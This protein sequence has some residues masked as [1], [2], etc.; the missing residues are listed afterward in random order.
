M[1][2]RRLVLASS[3]AGKAREFAALMAGSGWT[4]VLPRDAGLGRMEVPE[5]ARSYLENATL[6]AVAYA[7]ASGL[8]ALADDSGL[9]VDAL[10]GRP[11]VLSARFGGRRARTDRE[12]YE[13]L[14]RLLEGVP[15]ARRGARFRAVLV[16]ADPNGLN[17]AREGTVE[18]RIAAAPRG[19][20]GFGY[21]PVFELPDGRTMAELG[22][23]KQHLSHRARAMREM[24]AVL[25]DLAAGRPA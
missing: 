3:N 24:M 10:E 20:N 23:E 8:P 21:D 14:L 22:D 17:Y 16:L 1:P 12:R 19:E 15:P 18:G 25:R 11:G 9:E 2:D 6:K 7:T 4:L 5:G 13:H